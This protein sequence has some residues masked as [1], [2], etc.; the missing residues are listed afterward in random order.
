MSLENIEII[1]SEID[2]V[3]TDGL[4]ALEYLNNALFKNYYMRDFEAINNLKVYFTF[5]FL[6]SDPSV[7]YNVMRARNIP[8]YF[9]T[10]RDDKLTI[11]TKK[12]LPRYNTVP[13]NLL[14]IGST[15]SD[16]PCMQLAQLSMVPASITEVASKAAYQ[17]PIAPGQGVLSYVANTLHVEIERR[18]RKN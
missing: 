4:V 9:T 12:I 3:I 18:K 2:G 15:Q 8:A 14:Y 13:E 7:S 11:L 6:S 10:S 16:I 17:M 1:V 5:V